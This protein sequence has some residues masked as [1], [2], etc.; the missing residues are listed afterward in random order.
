MRSLQRKLQSRWTLVI[1]FNVV[2]ETLFTVFLYAENTVN[3]INPRKT[4]YSF[5]LFG[6]LSGNCYS[7]A[8]FI[9][10]GALILWN[11]SPSLLRRE[12]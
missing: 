7:L 11:T 4:C 5:F 1:L 9:G 12:L 6:K 3:A 2:L 10:N 8:Y